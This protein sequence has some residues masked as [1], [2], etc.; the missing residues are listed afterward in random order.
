MTYLVD[1]DW[2]I[3]YLAG[4][5]AARNLIASLLSDSIAISIITFIEI[6]EGIKR[7]PTRR[8]DERAFRTFLQG[9]DVFPVNRTVARRAAKVRAGL[10]LQGR[11]VRRRSLDLLIAATALAYNLTLVTR[12]MDDY[13]DIPGLSLY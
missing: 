1:T 9:V 11:S 3:D 2:M 10:R 13:G 7:S 6:Y 5:P 8:Q 12:N 4:E